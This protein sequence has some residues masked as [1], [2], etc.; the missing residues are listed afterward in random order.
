MTEEQTS[1]D[2]LLEDADS[3]EDV[4]ED[5]DEVGNLAVFPDDP[6][7]SGEWVDVHD[8]LGGPTEQEMEDGRLLGESIDVDNDDDGS[9][10]D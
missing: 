3:G 6:P 2:E 10:L 7:S 4:V 5:E 8:V 1:F 9:E